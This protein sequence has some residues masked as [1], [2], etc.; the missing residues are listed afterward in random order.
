MDK[1]CW[2]SRTAEE[3]MFSRGGKC[4]GFVTHTFTP[5]GNPDAAAIVE[6]DQTVIIGVVPATYVRFSL[7]GNLDKR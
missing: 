6:D 2:Y 1:A 4:F 3:K 5:Y 7:P